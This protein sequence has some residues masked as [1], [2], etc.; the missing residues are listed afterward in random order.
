MHSAR[1]GSGVFS[2]QSSPIEKERVY[3]PM[4]LLSVPPSPAREVSLNAQQHCPHVSSQKIPAKSTLES[5]GKCLIL[6]IKYLHPPPTPNTSNYNLFGQ[7][8]NI[9]T[10][11]VFNGTSRQTNMCPQA[12]NFK[13]H[14]TPNLHSEIL[15]LVYLRIFSHSC[16]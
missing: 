13:A 11:S 2:P 15:D 1:S 10:C 16:V 6:A 12:E 5:A 9:Y 8:C 7:L 14:L 4:V 3:D